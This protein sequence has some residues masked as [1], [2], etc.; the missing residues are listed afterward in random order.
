MR[1]IPPNRLYGVRFPKSFRDDA[2]WYEINAY[3]G[4]LMLLGSMSQLVLAALLLLFMDLDSEW[5]TILM[6][7]T[8]SLDAVGLALLCWLRLRRL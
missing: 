3:G 6:V 7:G 1:R 8:I 2:T 4:M 5:F